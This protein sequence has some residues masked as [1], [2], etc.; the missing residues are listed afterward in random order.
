MVT[1][2]SYLEDDHRRIERFLENSPEQYPEFRAALARHIGMEEKI[3]FPAIRN[4]AG[5]QQLHLDHGALVSLLVPTPTTA[6]LNAIRSILDRHNLIEE[7]PAGIYRQ[8]ERLASPD[9]ADRILA[10]L[11]SAPPV[12][13]NPHVDNAI[14]RDSIHAALARA[15]Y[16][17]EIPL[18]AGEGGDHR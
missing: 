8:F 2:S 5:V 6:I 16:S 3:L 14:V 11:Q 17:F 13:M 18:P 12:P 4:L 15:G 10:K 7:G 1:I 9:E